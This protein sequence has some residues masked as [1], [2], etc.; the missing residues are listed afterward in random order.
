M[1]SPIPVLTV[2]SGADWESRL[3]GELA[4]AAGRIRVVR[5]CVDLA[6]LL[7]AATAG[8]G[9]AALVAT[10]TR[11]LDLDAVTTLHAAGVATVGL[12]A[13]DDPDG[14]NRL[15]ALGFT[16]VVALMP[17]PPR[18]APPSSWPSASSP[19]GR[20][21]GRGS[22]GLS[23]VS[24]ANPGPPPTL[25]STIE[26]TIEPVIGQA[27]GEPAAPPTAPRPP[28]GAPLRRRDRTWCPRRREHRGHRVRRGRRGGVVTPRS[29]RGVDR[30]S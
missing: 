16:A 25:G 24:A 9:R 12:R 29:R 1:A 7:A 17:T 4:G 18:W 15:R 13:P 19:R 14:D 26:P 21:R 22:G 3:V 8:H 27:T 6:E 20:H 30:G 28:R 23:P 11:R 2:S 5:R 10:D